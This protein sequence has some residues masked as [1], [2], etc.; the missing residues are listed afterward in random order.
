MLVA[1][2]STSCVAPVRRSQRAVRRRELSFTRS[3]TW[4]IWQIF[5]LLNHENQLILAKQ[6]IEHGANVSCIDPTGQYALHKSMLLGNVT[7]LDFVELLLEGA[8][9]MRRT[10]E[11]DTVDV[12]QP[13]LAGAAQFLLNWSTT[14]ANIT[15]SIW[16]SFLARV[17]DLCRIS[18][19][20]SYTPKCNSCS[21]SG[22]KSKRCW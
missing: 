16:A 20:D 11:A 1:K 18:F 6:L 3:T 8:D 12:D 2:Q 15:L 4:P 9:Q 10:I 7:N 19:R 14:D 5:R 17:R 13:L 22:V 21:S